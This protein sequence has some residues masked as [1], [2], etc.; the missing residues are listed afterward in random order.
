ME[1]VRSRHDRAYNSELVRL[2]RE[3]Q[4]QR[5]AGRES[6]CDLQKMIREVRYF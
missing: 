5:E 4:K 1:P 2:S 6:Y 3:F